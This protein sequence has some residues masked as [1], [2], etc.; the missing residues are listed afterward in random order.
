MYLVFEVLIWEE[1][2]IPVINALKELRI[3]EKI[4]EYI[5]TKAPREM[6]LFL[7]V[8]PFI[9]GEGLGIIS[10]ILAAK[11]YLLSALVV[12]ACKIPLIIFA[13]AILEN[14]KE[15]LLSYRWFAVSYA[16]SVAQ[17]ERL[18]NYPLYIQITGAVRKTLDSIK[19]LW[20]K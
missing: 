10:G 19:T 4:L 15:K 6:V 11:L 12:Y 16:W 7:F 8:L 5:R 17:L 20:K 1:I 14:G 2:V 13:F 9:I 18:H 3:Y